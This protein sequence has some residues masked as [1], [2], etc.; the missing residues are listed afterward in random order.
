M[1]S[2]T[3]SIVSF[4]RASLTP[5]Q[6]AIADQALARITADRVQQQA[7]QNLGGIAKAGLG[8]GTLLAGLRAL[9]RLNREQVAHKELPTGGRVN[10][11]LF[12]P[13][14][15]RN[16]RLRSTPAEVSYAPPPS[17]MP[18]PGLPAPAQPKLASDLSNFASHPIGW[19]KDLAQGAMSGRNATK[20]MHLPWYPAAALATGVGAFGAGHVATDMIMRKIRDAA[21]KQELARAERE[22]EEALQGD[23]SAGKLASER[24]KLA[25]NFDRIVAVFEKHA[26]VGAAGQLASPESTQLA[27]LAAG[28]YLT[29]MLAAGGIGLR[30][31]YNSA[32]K[33]WKSNALQ[34]AQIQRLQSPNRD[35]PV[36]IMAEPVHQPEL[37]L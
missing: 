31:G 35:Q 19:V 9:T 36:E 1:S 30:A 24:S 5:E 11:E 3:N 8:A 15:K 37:T 13:V 26:N 7:F 33:N 22:Y 34:R 27:S 16:R 28:L 20:P 12:A 6:Q 32:K 29:S 10:V 23:L 14:R 25:S 17:I 21:M 4:K 2:Q 18:Y